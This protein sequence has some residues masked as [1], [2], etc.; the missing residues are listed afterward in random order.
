MANLTVSSIRHLYEIW[1]TN[2]FRHSEKQL[3][4]IRYELQNLH[5]HD[6]LKKYYSFCAYDYCWDQKYNIITTYQWMAYRERSF[7]IEKQNIRT[8]NTLISERRTFIWHIEI[9]ELYSFLLWPKC[10]KS[11]TKVKSRE[12]TVILEFYRWKWSKTLNE[13]CSRQWQRIPNAK[14]IQLLV[15]I[16]IP[17]I[18]L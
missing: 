15:L 14:C 2:G 9:V 17:S 3:I 10:Q 1:K 13:Y 8:L 12:S 5:S 16:H 18:T 4:V 11:L 7:K 6:I